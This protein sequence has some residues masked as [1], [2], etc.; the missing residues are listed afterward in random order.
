MRHTYIP[1]I[2]VAPA[3]PI[4][5]TVVQSLQ[6]QT[7]GTTWSVKLVTRAG[8]TLTAVR[9][10]IEQ[11]LALVIE[12]M[13]TW[14][15]E[16]DLSR[17]NRAPAGSWHALPD[18][19][20]DV[21]DCAL[22]VARESNGAYDPSAGMLVNLWGFGPTNRYDEPG[23]QPPSDEQVEQAR[24]LC[25]W[26]RLQLDRA[27]K[28]V[29]Q[30]GGLTLDFS[31]I[32]K[33]YAVDLVVRTLTALRIENFLVEIGGELRGIGIRP[34][35]QPWWVAIEQPPAQTD[36]HAATTDEHLLALYGCAVATSGDYRRSFTRGTTRYAH[37]I[38]PR[39]GRPL[40][41][42]LASVT[43]IHR[44]CMLADAWSTALGVMGCEEGLAC[45]DKLGIAALFLSRENHA[46]HAM[47]STAMK[48][49]LQ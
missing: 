33:G 46:L 38:D 1:L 42:H 36:D 11:Q 34:D 44:D 29:Q 5:G 27:E 30:P 40:Q 37:T 49:M 28:R 8:Q 41:H 22:Q 45:A 25:G 2:D 3:A 18:A 14:E 19:F 47:T 16:S 43:V 31:A 20:F 24:A 12:Q 17:Y 6:G 9:T 32:A 13:S 39:S 15:R 4:L 21:L 26:Q 10:A 48:A 35:G 7:M 23:F